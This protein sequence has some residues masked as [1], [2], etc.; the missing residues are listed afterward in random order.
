MLM[1]GVSLGRAVTADVTLGV[2]TALV[3]VRAWIPDVRLDIRYATDHNFVGRRI[4][5]YEAP[6]CLLTVPA[7]RA[8]A[9]VQDQLRSRGLSLKIYDCY[10][11]QRAVDAFVA[12]GEDLGD[13][14][15]KRE[16]Y[17]TVDKSRIFADGYIASRSG[18]SRGSTVDLTLV[19]VPTPEQP[20]FD[21]SAPQRSCE[22]P[23]SERF[24]DTSVDMGT[25]FDCFSPLSHTDNPAI[26][27]AAMEHRQLLKSLMLEQGFRNLAEEWWHYTLMD[28][29]YPDTYFDSPI[30]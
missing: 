24:P 23:Q 22:A 14:R 17:P 29:P 8:L 19:P 4:P 20:A 18:H 12:W 2:D 5:G 13:Q 1:L 3:D 16:F 15:M 11:P 26:G 9:A 7:A 25:G 21:A 6:R 27:G 30:R 10:R 28:E